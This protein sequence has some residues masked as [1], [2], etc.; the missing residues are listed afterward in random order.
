MNLKDY[1]VLEVVQVNIISSSKI[2]FILNAEK[3]NICIDLLNEDI[4]TYFSY[5]YYFIKNVSYSHFRKYNTKL[6]SV[7][8]TYTPIQIVDSKVRPVKNIT[9]MVNRKKKI[10]KLLNK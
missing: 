9:V 5:K 1:K 4:I 6:I 3:L 8:L 7:V 10:D 2:V